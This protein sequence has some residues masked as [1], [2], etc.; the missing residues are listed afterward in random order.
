MFD[1][2]GARVDQSGA[3]LDAVGIPITTAGRDQTDPALAFNGAD[4]LVAWTDERTFSRDVYGA[5]VSSDGSVL[6]SDGI[7]IGEGAGSQSHASVASEG[8]QSVV[9]FQDDRNT[10]IGWDDIYAAR[11]TPEGTV[12]DPAGIVVS[13]QPEGQTSPAAVFDGTNYLAAWRDRREEYH[14]PDLYGARVAPSGSVLDQ[15]DGLLFSGTGT[16]EGGVAVAHGSSNSAVVVY[17]RIGGEPPY[18][19]AQRVFVR[20]FHETAPPPPPPPPPPP[21]PPPPPPSPPPPFTP[22]RCVVPRV[23]GLPLRRARL[24]IVRRHCSVGRIQRIHTR[25]RLRGRVVRQSPRAGTVRR[26]G[27]PVRLVVGR[28]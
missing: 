21:A 7:L 12:L 5:R 20:L 17:S 25:G 18:G 22:P 14:H 3:V 24:R 28:R 1:V 8:G 15:P 26:R 11:V 19:G 4:Y 9:F 16:H 2:F 23:I 6:D 10:H 13:D 27:Y